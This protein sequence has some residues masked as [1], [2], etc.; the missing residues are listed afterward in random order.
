MLNYKLT[1]SANPIFQNY[2]YRIDVNMSNVQLYLFGK[3]HDSQFSRS[4]RRHYAQFSNL[5]LR[6]T[7][8]SEF[9]LSN[10]RYQRGVT[11]PTFQNY[12]FSKPIFQNSHYRIGVTM[13]NFQIIRTTFQIYLFVKPIVSESSL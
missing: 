6:Q 9:S 4:N 2:R 11:M 3:L 7:Q 12:L 10:S 5:P 13:P 1:C 8:F